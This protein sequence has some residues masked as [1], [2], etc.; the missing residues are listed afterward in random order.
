MSLETTKARVRIQTFVYNI[1]VKPYICDN[2][3]FCKAA[4]KIAYYNNT[5]TIRR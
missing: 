3:I 2:N 5:K 4:T 1:H